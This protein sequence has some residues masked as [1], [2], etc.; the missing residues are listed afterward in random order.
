MREPEVPTCIMIIALR[1]LGART[2]ELWLEP[3]LL[4]LRGTKNCQDER[5]LVDTVFQILILDAFSSLIVVRCGRLDSRR[6]DAGCG[7][8]DMTMSNII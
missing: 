4:Y 6:H 5:Q 1:R 8:A 7:A 3:R 2:R